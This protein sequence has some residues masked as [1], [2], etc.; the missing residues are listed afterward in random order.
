MV[1]GY[2][3]G[4]M[5]QW[6]RPELFTVEDSSEAA[7]GGVGKGSGGALSSRRAGGPLSGPGSRWG[8]CAVLEAA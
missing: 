3:L 2:S 4:K 5:T 6:Q 1:L 7:L 8:P